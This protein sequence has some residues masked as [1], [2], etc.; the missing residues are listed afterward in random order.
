MKRLK[1]IISILMT[2]IMV[3]STSLAAFADGKTNNDDLTI[4][5]STTV[6][7]EELTIGSSGTSEPS[8]ELYS[9]PED[10]KEEKDGE[11]SWTQKGEFPFVTEVRISD[12]NGVPIA[13]PSFDRDQK[14]NLDFYFK[15]P[16]SE[17]VKMGDMF[18]I[19]IP[20][21]FEL[22]GNISEQEIGP[23][24][25]ATWE[26]VDGVITIRFY[27]SLDTLS[28]VSGYMSIGCW[29]EKDSQLGADGED[30]VFEIAGNTFVVPVYK[31]DVPDCV[32]AKVEK[33]G[34][35]DASKRE[36]TW[37]IKVI[38][39]PKNSI[40]DGVL[41]K[42]TWD[43]YLEYVP[44]TFK[45]DG[46]LI[47][48]SEIELIENGFEYTMTEGKAGTKL[49]TYKTYVKDFFYTS[50]E[51]LVAN[52][53][54]AFMPEGEQ[55]SEAEATVSIVNNAISKKIVKYNAITGILSW[56][57]KVNS[58][59]L[60]LANASVVDIFPHGTEILTDTIKLNGVSYN[61]FEMTE[62]K[63]VVNLGE[64]TTEMSL[65]YD[66]RVTDWS[67]FT[68]DGGYYV[69]NVA[70][71][72]DE[73]NKIGETVG[74]AW[75]GVGTGNIP[76]NKT[77]KVKVNNVYGQY[78][79]WVIYINDPSSLDYQKL[80]GDIVIRDVLEES[81]LLPMNLAVTA[82]FPDGTQA[83]KYISPE[84]VTEDGKTITITIPKNDIFG[85]KMITP[86]C[87]FTIWYAS[88]I[89]GVQEGKFK[90]TVTV[91][92]GNKENS[93]TA[94]VDV[95]YKQSDMIAKKGS[96]NYEKEMYEWTITV[97][98]GKQAILN[99]KVIDNLPD[100][101]TPA[102]D[103]IYVNGEKVSF[104]EKTLSGIL[105]EY[106][107]E[108]LTISINGLIT[109][110]KTIKID[111]VSN[112]KEEATVKNS[113]VLKSD[114]ISDLSCEATVKYKPLPILQK[115]TDYVKGDVINWKVLIALDHDNLGQLTLTDQLNSGLS[116]SEDSLKM[117]IADIQSNGQ[118]V[119][120]SEQIKV[121]YNYDDQT[122]MLKVILPKDLDTHKSYVLSFSTEIR[123]KNL[124]NVTNSITFWGSSLDESATSKTVILK[125]TSSSSG[126]T[127]EAGSV[128]ILKRDKSDNKP[129]KGVAFQLLNSDKEVMEN[130]GWATT[131]EDGIAEFKDWLRLENTYY[132]Q[133]VRCLEG[134][135]FDD[136]MYEVKA[137]S[138]Q[139][140][141]LVEVFNEKKTEKLNIQGQKTWS[142][143]N[144][145]LGLRPEKIAIN[146]LADGNKIDTVEV[147]SEN[148]WTY[149]FS[150][151][152]KYKDGTAIMYTISEEPVDGYTST[153]DGYNVVNT[154]NHYD[155]D[156][157]PEKEKDDT[158]PNNSSLVDKDFPNRDF[159]IE[160]V[161]KD[162]Q[163][164]ESSV[165]ENQINDVETEK[166]NTQGNKYVP[167]TGDY[168]NSAVK[169]AVLTMTLSAI[170]IVLLKRKNF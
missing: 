144:N 82:Y 131:N 76:V 130:V 147:T 129:L 41:V 38:P 136:T 24:V 11:I 168:R 121:E 133:E 149:E 143:E 22:V 141:I 5:S 80:D 49:I 145:K 61:Q 26:V 124:T 156:E 72:Y 69:Q 128:K 116:F 59:K 166:P 25:D 100:G 135:V 18:T 163:Y 134:Y 57:V 103:Y 3:A 65:T 79:E 93:A 140:E 137:T 54:A 23:A 74:E 169:L 2:T 50:G 4:G 85:D 30:I 19:E 153:I 94:E 138:S 101:H 70:E 104:G 20:K 98:S 120:T 88:R 92:V 154:L 10:E 109:D 170:G 60:H 64:I 111:T 114:N 37:T 91:T 48:D 115:T 119:P 83:T 58:S 102:Y 106:D 40:L 9:S 127:G 148:N 110:T 15:I 47:S 67:K 63:L 123:D 126:I 34:T 6:E 56:E 31:E 117:S 75:I 45:V 1:K 132:I 161:D 62:G 89:D 146:L 21:G 162:T 39:E 51:N 150:N 125:T 8:L 81:T 12:E 113:A 52:K 78:I 55:A 158:K 43:S 105:A 157:P 42:D 77:G 165:E 27:E 142:D 87:S 96:Y 32:T 29:F 152:P 36:V 118:I 28:N 160:N 107:G 164:E 84:D 17:I 139:K 155:M 108:V 44:N 122:G 13:N 99:P 53:V 90:N 112:Q 159:Q 97:N 167:N 71:L 68:V 66:M 7:T 33:N 46:S 16:N 35:Y 14:I 73:Q 86:E 151:L 95:S